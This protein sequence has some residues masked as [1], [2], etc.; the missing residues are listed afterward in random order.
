MSKK[1]GNSVFKL[2]NGRDLAAPDQ[3][4]SGELNTANNNSI[5]NEAEDNFEERLITN[6]YPDLRALLGQ[7][8]NRGI[9][10]DDSIKD[11]RLTRKP[12]VQELILWGTA[13]K[14]GATRC[15]LVIN[16][17]KTVRRDTY[18]E[19]LKVLYMYGWV[20]P[21]G[22]RLMPFSSEKINN[23]LSPIEAMRGLFSFF[24]TIVARGG[25]HAWCVR[26]LHHVWNIRRGLRRNYFRNTESR[27]AAKEATRFE[28]YPFQTIWVPQALKGIGEL[29]NTIVGASKDALIY[30]RAKEVP[31]LISALNDAAKAIDLSSEIVRNV[32]VAIEDSGLTHNFEEWL[33]DHTESPARH[34][35]MKE[36]RDKYPDLKLGDFDYEYVIHRRILRTLEGSSRV[37]QLTRKIRSSEAAALQRNKLRAKRDLLRPL[38]GW[39]DKIRIETL[40]PVS[41]V[42]KRTVTVGRDVSIGR[43][44]LALGFSARSADQRARIVKLFRGLGDNQFRPDAEFDTDTLFGLFTR[45]D[46]YPNVE[47]IASVAVRIG[48]RRDK[49]IAF[50]NQFIHS[51][52]SALLQSRGQK[53][54]SGDEMGNTWNLS[55]S[56][57]RKVVELPAWIVDSE[58]A[59]LIRQIGVMYFLTTP[60]HHEL[61]RV[62]VQT[63]GDAESYIKAEL[64][65]TRFSHLRSY[66]NNFPLNH[67]Y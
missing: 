48:A 34:K 52:D 25:P 29:W 35:A 23:Q 2:P 30:L 54:S 28:D 61:S 22:G 5:I 62:R 47:R 10:G 58:V 37:N 64:T 14:E 51:M 42:R 65:P 4:H 57:I 9:L 27:I 56:S 16:D 45:P 46:I 36:E 32:A 40:D 49:A 1:L 12:T 59:Y 66:E 60:H 19:Y 33:K 18:G 31:G 11:Y 6:A 41:N 8:M 43:I 21:Q 20:V 17:Y 39:L 13:I 26:Y 24:R 53:F 44:E 55:Y 3:T 7:R 63:F 50:A 67:Y 38:F 15:G